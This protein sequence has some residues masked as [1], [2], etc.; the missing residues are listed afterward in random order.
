MGCDDDV[1]HVAYLAVDLSRSIKERQVKNYGK[2]RSHASEGVHLPK[3]PFS[4]K[5]YV[6]WG[7]L[8][9][10]LSLRTHIVHR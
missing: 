8:I 4:K 6:R 3:S 1:G 9:K 2:K 7:I 10:G 5:L